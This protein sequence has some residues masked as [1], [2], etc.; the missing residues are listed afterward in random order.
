M[1]TSSPSSHS[2]GWD[3]SWQVFPSF[4]NPNPV[5]AEVRRRNGRV[6]VDGGPPPHV[7]GYRRKQHGRERHTNAHTPARGPSTRTSKLSLNHAVEARLPT[8]RERVG[9]IH[10]RRTIEVRRHQHP[11]TGNARRLGRLDVIPLASLAYDHHPVTIPLHVPPD[12][13]VL[14][15]E[16]PAVNRPPPP[17]RH[18]HPIEGGHAH[19][20][21]R[22]GIGPGLGH[23]G[24]RPLHRVEERPPLH[25]AAVPVVGS[26]LIETARLHGP[27]GRN[28]FLNLG[29]LACGSGTEIA[30]VCGRGF[31]P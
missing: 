24:E 12:V 28:S 7:V 17:E 3:Y 23:E 27:A 21:H 19:K 25:L 9:E 6:G 14:R 22:V 20:D 16:R 4:T 1:R 30:A 13:R 26:A 31:C 18:I 2:P 10:Q 5:A 11:G 15:Q 29:A 8:G